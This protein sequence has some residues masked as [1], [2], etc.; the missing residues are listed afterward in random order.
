M[1]LLNGVKEYNVE[2]RTLVAEYTIM[3]DCLFYDPLLGGVPGWVGFEFIAQAISVLSGLS[4]RK[5]GKKPAFGFILSVSAMKV[6]SPLIKTGITVQIE[7]VENSRMD[8][9]Y[10]FNGEVLEENKKIL[11]GRIT[12]M[13][14]GK[15]QMKA[16]MKESV[17]IE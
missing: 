10:V 14:V 4:Y 13:D 12:V 3:E 5:K 8:A 15:E 11:E 6:R 2:K 17:S 7:V 9:I 1:L 16:I